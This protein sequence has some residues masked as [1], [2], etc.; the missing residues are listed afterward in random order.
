MTTPPVVSIT[1]ELL[2]E[3]E[4]AASKATPGGRIASSR[5]MLCRID[6]DSDSETLATVYGESGENLANAQLI[7]L[8]NPATVL[9]LIARIRELEKDAAR[10]DWVL[11]QGAIAAHSGVRG[12]PDRYQIEWPLLGEVFGEWFLSE[13]EAIDAAMPSPPKEE[14]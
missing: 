12:Q 11:E 7:C 2:A 3:L 8:C 1:D 10:L 6:I 14:A 9:A 13:R 5:R 4:E